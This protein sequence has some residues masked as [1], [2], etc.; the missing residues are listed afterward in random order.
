MNKGIFRFGVTGLQDG[1]ENIYKNEIIFHLMQNLRINSG[2]GMNTVFD[3]NLNVQI[4]RTDSDTKLEI[5]ILCER[6]LPRLLIA[7][8]EIDGVIDEVNK[9][10]GIKST[11]T[12]TAVLTDVKENTTIDGKDHSVL[13][14]VR[15]NANSLK[16]TFYNT[17]M[18]KYCKELVF[19]HLK[20]IDNARVRIDNPNDN[21]V[22]SARFIVINSDE[23][24]IE[25]IRSQVYELLEE[26]YIF[27]T[28]R[29]TYQVIK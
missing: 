4:I 29:A 7:Q 11:Y 14:D 28:V 17:C 9:S 24:E 16:R 8:K 23:E 10:L 15:I 18:I 1:C 2:K 20:N 26:Y 3:Y 19:S 5:E 13:I 21:S 22:F 25:K 6:N 27:V 12:H